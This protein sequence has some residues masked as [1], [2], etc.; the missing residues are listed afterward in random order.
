[1]E[2]QR[3]W[4]ALSSSSLNNLDLPFLHRPSSPSFN[5]TLPLSSWYF[6]DLSYWGLDYPPLTAYHS[7]LLGAVARLSPRTAEYVTLRP[8]T[9]A[10]PAAIVNWEASFARMEERG[11]MKSWLRGTVVVGDLLVWVSAVVV[12]CR[13]NYGGG[14]GDKGLRASW[15]AIMTILFQPGLILIDS[16]HFQ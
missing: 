15:V 2:A 9:Y 10:E 7:L 4:L 11:E 8:P 5:A 16:G 13:R 12:F 14:K 3:H 1:M 6:H